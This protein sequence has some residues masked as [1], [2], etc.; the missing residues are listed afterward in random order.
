MIYGK[1][2]VCALADF[3]AGAKL[4]QWFGVA[5]LSDGAAGMRRIRDPQQTRMFDPFDGVLSGMARRRILSGW[6]GVFR[7]VAQFERSAVE[8]GAS[9]YPFQLIAVEAG[10][11]TYPFQLIVRGPCLEQSN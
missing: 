11:S 5:D 4:S 2:E 6:Q 1:S 3:L 7:A 9:T 10:A 8:A